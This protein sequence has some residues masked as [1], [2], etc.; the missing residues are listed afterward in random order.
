MVS[1]LDINEKPKGN[2][3]INRPLDSRNVC[4]C[5]D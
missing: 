5:L 2:N 4:N 3:E 1:K